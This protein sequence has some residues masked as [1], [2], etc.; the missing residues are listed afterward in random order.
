LSQAEIVSGISDMSGERPTLVVIAKDEARCIARCLDSARALTDRMLVLD[1]GS[2]DATPD[3]ARAC[4]A[5]VHHFEWVDD[6]SAARNRALEL[7]NAGWNL[8][9]D[10]DEWLESAEGLPWE[11]VFGQPRL[12]LLRVVSIDQSSGQNLE[13]TSW[14]PRLLPRGVRYQGRIHEQPDTQLP[15]LKTGISIFHDGYMTEQ[16]QRKRGR[17]RALIE[18][19][20]AQ[21]PQDP[22]LLYQLGT[23]HEGLK[24]FVEAAD[25]YRQALARLP[26][27]VAYEHPLLVRTLHCLCRSG[28][29]DEALGLMERYANRYD[30]SPDFHFAAGNAYLDKA[31]RDPGQAAQRWLPLAVQAW[32]HCL[33]IGDQPELEGSVQGRGSFL[34]DHNL[35]VV[36]RLMGEHKLALAM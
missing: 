2:S 28:A 6:F 25:C 31:L 15:R 16:M 20:L 10:A 27:A 22:Y 21:D 1:T 36:S 26:R 18:Q 32:Q 30:H 34:A 24:A 33:A 35:E 14:Q 29:V 5:E 9:L 13:V 23:E 17:N 12:G 7:A 11:A 3:I 19:S 8:I 4:G